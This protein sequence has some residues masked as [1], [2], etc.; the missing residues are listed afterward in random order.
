VRSF[1]S[2][3]HRRA[4]AASTAGA[5]LL[6]LLSSPFAVAADKL[7]DKQHTVHQQ[8]Q[9]A[10]DDLDESSAALRKATAALAAAQ[11]S[12]RT[13]QGKL[14][15]AQ[16]RVAAARIVDQ[17]MQA[18]L[19]AAEQQLDAASAELATGQQQ[20]ADQRAAFGN[21][22]V[23]F[24]EH[25]DPQLL[26]L[27]SIMKAQNP[28][29]VIRRLEYMHTTAGVQ[30]QIYDELRAAEV[31]LKV[32]E[33]QVEKARDQVAVQRKA[34]AAHLVLMTQLESQA[35]AAAQQV[36]SLVSARAQAEDAAQEIRKRDAATLAKL[37]R[38]EEHIKQLILEAAQRA[39]GGYHGATNGILNKPV[40]GPITSPYGWRVHPIY[41]YWGLHDGDDFGADCGQPLWAVASGRVLAEYYSDVWGNRLYLDLGN[42]NGKNLTAIY[43]HLSRYR[44][45]VGDRVSRGDTVGYVGTTG[46]STG[47]HLHFTLMVN[48]TPVDPA[49]Y[50]GN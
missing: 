8:V 34:A 40:D 14:A 16:G 50:F 19:A 6:G 4:L 28:T 47:C 11:A 5:V 21:M 45:G 18:K 10:H 23:D 22:M 15:G 41:H 20:V 31:L 32:R 36:Q 48:G 2:S 12:L 29:D 35:A 3:R 46:W 17:Q 1:P 39:K 7:K 38:E 44:V 33:Q 26:G 25:G 43:N 9:Q 27:T 30:D 13:A 37:K 24:Y 49:P 42:Y